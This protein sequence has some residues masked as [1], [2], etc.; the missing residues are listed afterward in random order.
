MYA[1]TKSLAVTA[2]PLSATLLNKFLEFLAPLS[3]SAN[4]YL[5]DLS[6]SASIALNP[7]T[8]RASSPNQIV[9]LYHQI[10]LNH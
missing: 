8:P 4:L 10:Y 9:Y 5:K 6:G 1:S 7:I 3:Y 2:P